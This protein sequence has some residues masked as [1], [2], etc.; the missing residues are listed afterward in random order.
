MTGT[1]SDQALESARAYLEA[2]DFAAAREGALAGLG[3]RPDD[4]ALLQ[5]AGL[6]S[7][8]LGLDDAAAYLERAAAAGHADA[9]AWR[10]LGAAFA[11]LGRLDDAR[12]AFRHAVE[13]LPED[14]GVL[15][16]VGLASLAA[17]RTGDAVAYL[18]EAARRDP[19]S[20]A[21]LRGLFEIHRREGRLGEALTAALRVQERSP[22]DPIA[23]LDVA[24][25]CLTLGRFDEATAAFTRLRGIDEE[26][27]HEVYAYHGLIEVELRRGRLRRAL[28]LAVDATKV[29]RFGR[30]TDVLAYVVS[31]VFG[32]RDRPAPDRP[33]VDAVLASSRAEHRRL[34]AEAVVV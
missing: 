33:E 25:V 20:D 12:G 15:L 1:S 34:H 24:E 4:A 13:L 9:A 16:D 23:A 18:K 26:P 14:P 6:A 28:N 3:E 17:G 29:D 7:L 32:E 21:A 19:T 11:D 30:T 2:G 8:E 22:E 31:Q 27:E 5:V 10:E